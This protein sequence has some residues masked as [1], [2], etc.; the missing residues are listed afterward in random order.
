MSDEATEVV[1]GSSTDAKVGAL[2]VLGDEIS[3]CCQSQ[4]IWLMCQQFL[5]LYLNL[6]LIYPGG[7]GG[8]LLVLRKCS[9]GLSYSNVVQT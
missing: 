7:G 1:G 3:S 4:K 2:S 6:Y 8:R 9:A 5:V